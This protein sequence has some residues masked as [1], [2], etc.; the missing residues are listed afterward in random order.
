MAIDIVSAEEIHGCEKAVENG[1]GAM[2]VS[3]TLEVGFDSQT[4]EVDV[5]VVE[6]SRAFIKPRLLG[7]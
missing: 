7:L 3:L 1:R 4:S 5:L 6:D 2:G